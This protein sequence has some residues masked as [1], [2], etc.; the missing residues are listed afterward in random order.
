MNSQHVNYLIIGAGLAG[1][2]AAQAIRL[3]DPIG[4]ITL[5]GQEINRPYHRPPLTRNYLLRKVARTGLITLPLGWYADNH[6]ELSTGRRATRI[7]ASRRAAA[8]DTGSEI[9]FDKLLIAT[10]VSARPLN[11]PGAS[12]PNVYDLR[13]IEDAELIIHAIE[14]AIT[15]GRL[16]DIN[17]RTGGRGRVTVIGGGV[18]GVELAETLTIA[19]L[20]VDLLVS[21]AHP[22]AKFAGEQVGGAITRHLEKN[23]VTVH[24]NARV[25][26]MQG[27]GRVQRVYTDDG[28][29]VQCDFVVT[30]IGTVFNRELLRGTPINAE[31][32]ILVDDH[33]R[34]NVEPIYAAGDC[35]A[36][37]DPLFG[38]HRVLD[39]WNSARLLG[40]I[41]GANMAGD[42]SAYN[43]VNHFTSE[44]F[45][46]RVSVWGE[47]R[48][49]THRHTRR[50]E[51][52]TLI[53][54]GVS[55]TNKISQTLMLG[56]DKSYEGVLH[57]FV[58]KRLDV[59]A[60]I[61][62]LTDPAVDLKSLL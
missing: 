28:R 21:A 41:A 15:E 59:N 9:V 17:N 38:K 58:Q 10:G 12:Y 52:E 45:G 61:E 43:L 47:S 50:V 24:A 22:W 27:D 11:V 26:H 49:V 42:D 37:F 1:S 53:E 54:F 2:A 46:K 6:V 25:S 13:T 55:A 23:G 8:L 4:S 44:V 34:T 39:H 40:A 7:D 30:A 62:S 29:E 18:L 19:G 14:H 16:H 36:V 35:A 33:C 56:G 57:E 5:V 3:R 48:H 31:K 20:K 32:H 51:G 60:K